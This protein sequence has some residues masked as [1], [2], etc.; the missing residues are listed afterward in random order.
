MMPNEVREREGDQ[1]LAWL[2]HT[3]R[4]ANMVRVDASGERIASQQGQPQDLQQPGKAAND[5]RLQNAAVAGAAVAASWQRVVTGNAQRMARRLA[6]GQSL[7]PELLSDAL[8]LDVR[9]AADF[10][11]VDPSDFTEHELAVLLAELA[12][13]G[14]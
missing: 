11:E 12:L 3:M 10:L 6:A 14:V 13:N 4:P 1:P 7:S 5:S 2:N 9:V 8:G